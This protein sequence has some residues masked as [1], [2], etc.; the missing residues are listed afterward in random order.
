MTARLIIRRRI[1]DIETPVGAMLKLGAELPGSFLFESIAGGERLGRYSFIGIEPGRWFRIRSGLAET[2]STA[3]FADAIPEVGSPI[4]A[5]RRFVNAARAEAPEGIPPMAS[6]AFGYL[7]YDMIQYVEPVAITKPDVLGVPEAL[8]LVPRVVVIFDHLYQELLLVGRQEGDDSTEIDKLLDDVETRLEHLASVPP[9]SGT[10]EPVTL[11]SDTSK[12][13]YFEI[14]EQCRAYIKAGDIFQVVPSQRFST[15][16]KRKPISFY[17][18]LRRLNPSAFMFHMNLGDVC[19]VGSSP[20]ILVRVRDGRVAIRPIAGTRPRSGNAEEDARRADDLLADPK[21]RAEHLMLLD[22]G[23]NDVGRVAAYGSVTVT[24][25]FVVERY[26][27]VMHIVS[28]V[29]GDLR[30]GL[31]AVDALLAGFPAGTVSGAPKIRAMQIID[32]METSRRGIYGGAVGYFGWNGDLDTCIALR[33]AVIKDGQLHIQAGGGVVLDSVPQ[34]EYD[35][36]VHKS[37]ALSRAAELSA[38]Y[39]FDQ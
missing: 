11:T 17:R 36:T 5:L 16:F 29:E 24:E 26:S 18:A 30:E 21:E 1:G 9:K 39:E 4:D 25:S 27:H 35:E 10:A 20:E 28:H 7:G 31:D 3:D 8:L 19:L 33:T 15:P 2:S 22:L 23:R 12:D 6:G 38:A 37:G 13:R 32:E 34:Y 14:V